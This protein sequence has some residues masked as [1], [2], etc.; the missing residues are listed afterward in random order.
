MSIL[1][2]G[3]YEEMAKIIFQI[4]SNTNFICSFGL[5]QIDCDLKCFMQSMNDD[6]K[7]LE[8]HRF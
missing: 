2:I 5:H 6:Q 7:P 3:F 1:N 8:T 4:S